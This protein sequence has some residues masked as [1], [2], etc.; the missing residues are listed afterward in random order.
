MAQSAVGQTKPQRWRL[1]VGRPR[2]TDTCRP[3]PQ[4]LETMLETMPAGGCWRRAVDGMGTHARC[5]TARQLGTC[6]A[7]RRAARRRWQS[8]TT[9]THGR[10]GALALIPPPR[11]WGG[12]RWRQ[13]SDNRGGSDTAT[14]CCLRAMCLTPDACRHSPG[15]VTAETGRGHSPDQR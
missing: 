2:I 4:W 6:H 11:G 13:M 14:R 10:R 8:A 15:R 7:P 1:A 5:A 9:M 12:G 3:P